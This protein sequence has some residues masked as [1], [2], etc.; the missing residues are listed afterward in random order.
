MTAAEA[1]AH[2]VH[3]A[4]MD[5]IEQLFEAIIQNGIVYRTLLALSA[6]S[7]NYLGMVDEIRHTIEVS[8]RL[9]HVK[10]V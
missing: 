8:V 9:A 10:S 2:M 6:Q 5:L 3:L 1:T 4:E 7:L